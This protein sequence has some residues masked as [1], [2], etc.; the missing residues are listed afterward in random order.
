MSGFLRKHAAERELRCP[1]CAGSIHGQHRNGD[2]RNDYPNKR[3]KNRT[4]HAA[5]FGRGLSASGA[6]SACDRFDA[7]LCIVKKNVQQ[8]G[9]YQNGTRHGAVRPWAFNQIQFDQH[10]GEAESNDPCIKTHAYPTKRLGI[11][12]SDE[13]GADRHSNQN[14]RNKHQ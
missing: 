9:V 5:R 3:P 12:P 4:G 10:P 1:L 11:Q 2:D 6:D 7:G 8:I 13:I 14:A